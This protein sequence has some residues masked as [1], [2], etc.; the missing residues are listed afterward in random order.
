MD[1]GQYYCDVLYYNTET[2]WRYDNDKIT[3]FR[4]YP[5]NINYEILHEN[6]QNQAKRHIIKVSDG[7]VSMLQIKQTFSY[8]ELT[9]FFIGKSVYEE[10]EKLGK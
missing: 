8:T 9:R 3:N 1:S 2:W 4:G 7:I 6:K 5:E 10:I